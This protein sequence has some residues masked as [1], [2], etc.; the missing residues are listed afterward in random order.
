MSYQEEGLKDVLQYIKYAWHHKEYINL[1]VCLAI[2]LLYPVI[3][4]VKANI[5]TWRYVFK[6]TIPKLWQNTIK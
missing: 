6:V 1:I 3:Y 4:V 5:V 2:V